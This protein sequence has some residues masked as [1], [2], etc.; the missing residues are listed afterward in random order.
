[1][2]VG[3]KIKNSEKIIWRQRIA[4]RLLRRKYW[5]FGLVLLGITGIIAHNLSAPVHG[6]VTSV[7]LKLA[8]H[9]H[10]PAAPQ[11]PPAT[12]QNSYF[13]LSLPTG[14][15]VP[16]DSPVV[17]GLLYE[18]TIIKPSS[19]GSL[20]IS[21]AL[22]NMPDGGLESDSSYQSRVRQADRYHFR[23]QI[24]QPDTVTVAN[25]A[26]SVSVVA[27][28]PHGGYLASIAIA[29][30]VDSPVVNN[31]NEELAALQSLI[32]GWQWQH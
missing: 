6:H 20:I 14:Y 18:Q 16:A 12:L 5:L 26:Q 22:K 31:N 25:D 11:L 23:T 29:T 2:R 21:I 17:P 15:R 3:K 30:G 19:T 9:A 8:K 27:F 4:P 28:W 7:D 1:M 24:A 32:S 10:P 13:S